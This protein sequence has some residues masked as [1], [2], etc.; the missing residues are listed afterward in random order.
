M[1]TKFFKIFSLLFGKEIAETHDLSMKNNPEWTSLK[2]IE[3]ILTMEEE[4]GITFDPQ[5]IPKL[6]S[7]KA[8]W[9]KISELTNGNPIVF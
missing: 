2:H 1:K 5:D 3:I 4:F 6:T 9:E 8:L 7:Q